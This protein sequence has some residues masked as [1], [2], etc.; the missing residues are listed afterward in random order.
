MHLHMQK[1]TVK[2]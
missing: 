2:G 1:Q